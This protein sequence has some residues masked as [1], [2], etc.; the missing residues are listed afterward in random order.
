MVYKETISGKYGSYWYMTTMKKTFYKI[1]FWSE[2]FEVCIQ[3]EKI[4]E[5]ELGYN[6]KCIVSW[7]TGPKQWLFMKGND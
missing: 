2:Q 5:E 1:W 3:E 4:K 6:R 7:K